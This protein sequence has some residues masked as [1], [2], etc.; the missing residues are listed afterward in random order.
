MKIAPFLYLSLR[1]GT[2]KQSPAL[3]KKSFV[4]RSNCTTVQA[5]QD[6]QS[7][8]RMTNGERHCEEER[9]SNLQL[10]CKGFRKILSV[11]ETANIS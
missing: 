5:Q 4:I 10:L 7:D 8:F 9:R 2:T 6:I 3:L 1:G 11:D